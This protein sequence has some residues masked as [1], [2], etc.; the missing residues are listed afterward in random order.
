MTQI[1]IRNI[2]RQLNEIQD[3]SLWFD[4][5]F[6]DKFGNLSEED[7]FVRPVPHIHSVAE[8]VSH[9]LEWRKECIRRCHGLKTELMNS[10]DDWKDDTDLKKIGWT[11]LKNALYESRS[12]LIDLI[13]NQDDTYLQTKFLDTD[14]NF[15]YLIEGIIH[16]DLY[17]LGQIG[18]TI[19]L[20]NKDK[21]YR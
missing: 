2:I 5:S 13:V 18:I 3:G 15:H 19:K 8:H 4:Q 1:L 9:M 7:A 6:K 17:H 14:Y 12:E 10:P 21:N 11:D 20:L 16:H